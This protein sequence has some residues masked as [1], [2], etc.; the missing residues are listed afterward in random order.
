MCAIQIAHGRGMAVIGLLRWFWGALGEPQEKGARQAP[1]RMTIRRLA[2]PALD[3]N[4][5]WAHLKPSA[6]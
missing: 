2:K 5:A 3:R 1:S 6:P 4:Q